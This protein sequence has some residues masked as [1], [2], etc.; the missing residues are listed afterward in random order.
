[1][2]RGNQTEKSKI[3][4]NKE[5]HYPYEDYD[6]EDDYWEETG[7]NQEPQD[8]QQYPNNQQQPNSTSKLLELLILEVRKTIMIFAG[9]MQII[10]APGHEV[11]IRFWDQ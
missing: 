11:P 10:V 7:D 9:D 8:S 6:D 5:K 2:C 3:K 1:M 4:R